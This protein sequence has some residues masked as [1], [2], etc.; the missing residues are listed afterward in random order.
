MNFYR[1]AQTEKVGVNMKRV[2]TVILGLLLGSVTLSLAQVQMDHSSPERTFE[3]YMAAA[4]ALSFELTDQCYTVEFLVFTQTNDEYMKHRNVDHLRV[5]Y[6]SMANKPYEVEMYGDKAIIRFA[7]E[8][9]RPQPLYFVKEA[10]EWKMDAMFMFNNVIMVDGGTEI[11]WKWKYPEKNSEQ[12][13]I[14]K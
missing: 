4:K 7:P 12:D 11:E 2:F 10:G 9:K 8:F 13:W 6:N 14:D 3:S 5:S 1:S